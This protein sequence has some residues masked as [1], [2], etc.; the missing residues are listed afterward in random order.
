M[1]TI[2]NHTI[3]KTNFISYDSAGGG[4]YFMT[5]KDKE[6]YL[7][8]TIEERFSNSLIGGFRVK[9]LTKD[10]SFLKPISYIKDTEAKEIYLNYNF[11]I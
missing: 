7:I 1:K 8:L 11:L 9:I 3:D 10:Y 4:Y 5:L 6:G 2:A